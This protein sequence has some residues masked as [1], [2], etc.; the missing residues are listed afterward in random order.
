MLKLREFLN[1]VEDNENVILVAN[2]DECYS[3]LGN[4]K[5]ENWLLALDWFEERFEAQFTVIQLSRRYGCVCLRLGEIRSGLTKQL[6]ILG[7]D[8]ATTNAFINL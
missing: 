8:A 1:A 5:K 4:H 7:N 6:E 3:S 2:D